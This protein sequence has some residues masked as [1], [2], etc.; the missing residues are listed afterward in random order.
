MQT[1]KRQPTTDATAAV[2]AST[3]PALENQ[4]M[5]RMGMRFGLG[6]FRLR[7]L[8]VVVWIAV[9]LASV[10]FASKIGTV[11]T[12]GGFTPQNSDAIR[13]N[14]VAQQR[15]HLPVAQVDVIFHSDTTPVQD[16]AF[17]Q[18]LAAFASRAEG[19]A[20]VTGVVPGGTGTDGRTALMLVN[21]DQSVD[22]LEPR[23]DAFHQLLPT[24]ANQPA[25]AYLT[26]DVAVYNS[27]TQVATQDTEKADAAA[28]PIALLVLLV[29]FATVVAALM[30]LIL[31]L[32]TVPV[33]LAIVYF[34]AQ[35]V[36][37]NI[38][39]LSIASIIGLGLSIDY[40]LFLV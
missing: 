21:F 29:V 9:L 26:G 25:R 37:S 4:G 19:F 6:V 36:T 8:I 28:L 11:L 32:V 1:E 23:L 40:S 27:L 35:H 7:W 33:A 38:V 39:V 30:P 5:F 22:A 3:T 17:Q 24:G 15:L 10:P 16:A 2:T 20:H 34:I 18:E 31:A 13:V 12:G 14:T